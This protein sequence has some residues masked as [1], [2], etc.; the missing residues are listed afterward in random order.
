MSD[1]EAAHI[2]G[3]VDMAF[4]YVET[5]HAPMNIG[6]VSV[7]DGKISYDDL[8]EHIDARIHLAPLY[9]KRL[10]QAPLKVGPPTWMVDPD[11]FTGNH[12]FK[13]KLPAPGTEAQLRELT[14][15]LVSKPLSRAKPLWE[16]HLIDGL[17]GNRT[18]LFFKVHHAMV[19]GLSAIELFTLLFD[20]SPEISDP[21]KKPPFDP[22]PIP[23]DTQLVVDAVMKDLPHK[24]DVLGKIGG[25]LSFMSGVLADKDKRRK[26][27]RGVATLISD[28][29]TLLKP[30]AINGKNSGQQML[31]WAEFPMAEV[32]AIRASANVSVNDVMLAVL[33][34]AVDRYE[35]AHGRGIQ[36]SV[37]VLVPV[38][39]RAE[40]EKGDFGNRIAVLP[41]DVPLRAP[42]P[43][44][45]LQ[46]VHDYTL[47][48]KQSY[49][50]NT[51]D[52]ILSLPSLSPAMV[53]PL[54]WSAA[55]TV[56]ALVA[57][58]WCTNVSGPQFPVYLL[59][60]EMQH[61]YG[62]FPLNPSMGLACV[63]MSYNQRMTMTLV[64][65]TGIIPDAQELV[66]YLHESYTELRAAAKVDPKP[67]L[68][69]PP[70]PKTEVPKPTAAPPPPKVEVAVEV[71]KPVPPPTPKTEV[72]AEAPLQ[73]EV[74]AEASQPA[75]PP[76][77][78]AEIV[79]EP[80]APVS[81]NGH[82]AEPVLIAA[83]VAPA[84]E[85]G[86]AAEPMLVAIPTAPVISAAEP[87]V[88]PTPHYKLFSEAWAQEF[89]ER[90]N[91]SN[92]Y[93]AASKKW[94]AGALAFVMKAAPAHGFDHDTAVVMDLLKGE[95][96]SA[97]SV[98]VGQAHA[99]SAFVI[100]GDHRAWMKVMR[101]EAA[102]LGMLVRGELQLKKGMMV[103]LLP[104][105]QSAQ[106]L[107]VC[108]QR[109]P[110]E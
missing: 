69:S 97:H 15:K 74:P 62:Y 64:T 27:L 86:H 102:P 108:A 99:Q 33:G 7:F 28:N 32:R 41:I 98:T 47:T 17:E 54:I 4:L 19:D 73:T 100:E 107:L 82:A 21:P 13:R 72:P 8:L 95:C 85:N 57:H 89:R 30:L 53:Q 76:A 87:E 10:V 55:P 59:G 26:M 93:R 58:T 24:L 66:G 1:P 44:N 18:A 25:T 22:P 60:R 67:I 110:W 49:L 5:E 2:L 56:F 35:Q 37:R 52:A 29:L 16:V 70:P 81:E 11:Y 92:A 75:E 77:P 42:D 105:T 50:S 104:F 36:D 109:V 63:V 103:R 45:R 83:P 90:I 34:G 91:D 88:P 101:G 61:S 84:N 65:D 51:I 20:L 31:T 80:A 106:E 6:A 48:M 78:A 23:S 96:R 40:Q 43:L 46:T 79:P 9:Q 39:M 38:N 3:P 71:P 68:S 94:T 12:V 14:G